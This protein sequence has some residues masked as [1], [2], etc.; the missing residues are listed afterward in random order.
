[1][2]LKL[3]LTAALLLAGSATT[4]NAATMPVATN[5]NPLASILNTIPLAGPLLTGTIAV[6]GSQVSV[7]PGIGPA[8][9]NALG[10]P[11]LSG[12]P[13]VTQ[14]INQLPLLGPTLSNLANAT[15]AIVV[16][17]PGIGPTLGGVLNGSTDLGGALAGL[18]NPSVLVYELPILGPLLR[19]TLLGGQ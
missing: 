14:V 13:N 8:L 2:N 11:S 1:M 6:V 15:G 18:P 9:G 12:L 5:A 19:G 17:V 10:A 16:A 7:V 3:S 4:V